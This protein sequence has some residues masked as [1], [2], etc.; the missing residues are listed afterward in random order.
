MTIILA[1]RLG[2]DCRK[3]L[4]MDGTLEDSPQVKDWGVE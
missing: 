4:Q 1:S 2:P 3:L